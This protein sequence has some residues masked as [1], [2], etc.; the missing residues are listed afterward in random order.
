MKNFKRKWKKLMIIYNI[1]DVLAVLMFYP[2]IPKLLNYPPDSIDNAFQVAINGLTYTQQYIS[3][4]I[5]CIFIENIILVITYKNI[6]KLLCKMNESKNIDKLYL[7]AV[8]TVGRTPIIIYLLQVIAPVIVIAMTF[9]ILNGNIEVILKVTLIFFAMLLSIATISYV[10][11]KRVFKDILIDLFND[12]NKN[13]DIGQELLNQINK[14]KFESPIEKIKF[15]LSKK[16]E[17]LNLKNSNLDNIYLDKIE[18]KISEDMYQRV[19]KRVSTEAKELE[20]EIKELKE[21]LDNVLENSKLEIDYKN[22]LEEF[23]NMSSPNREMMLRLIDKI[24]VHKDKQLD[25][26]FNFKEL[27]NF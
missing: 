2:I 11:A 18:G 27:N 26:Y 24:E 10:F 21:K 4:L 16:E 20:L 13:K 22:L 12:T 15:E 25:I 1:I 8:K 5:L 19:F 7:K 23:I 3:I 9:L 6:N 17:K 14:V